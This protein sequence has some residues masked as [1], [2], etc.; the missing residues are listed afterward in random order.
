LTLGRLR[1]TRLVLPTRTMFVLLRLSSLRLLIWLLRPGFHWRHYD[2]RHRHRHCQNEA[3]EK[4][5]FCRKHV[6]ALMM[7]PECDHHALGNYVRAE[8]FHGP[9]WNRRL[10]S[11]RRCFSGEDSTVMT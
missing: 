11:F 1:L 6:L 8:R 4:D 5:G 3:G 10:R 2:Q 9:R 7:R